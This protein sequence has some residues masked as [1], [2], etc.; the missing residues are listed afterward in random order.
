MRCR[1]LLAVLAAGVGAIAGEARAAGPWYVAGSIGGYFREDATGSTTITNGVTTAPAEVARSF[2]PGALLNATVGYRFPVRLRAEIEFG[3]AQYGA[4]SITPMVPPFPALN[5]V[6]FSHPVG[7]NL[8]RLMGTANLFYDLPVAG[9]FV[10]YV[11]GGLGVMHVQPVTIAFQ[12]ASGTRFTSRLGG[13]DK[14]VALLEAGVTVAL[15]DAIAVVPAYSYIHSA[16]S[17]HNNGTE[18]AH[19]VKLGMRYSF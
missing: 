7:S 14:G 17:V 18:I 3:Y 11:G 4:D 10:P 8:H 15:T 2:D 6:T 12:S 1:V 5:G 13:G 19:V 9:R 16:G